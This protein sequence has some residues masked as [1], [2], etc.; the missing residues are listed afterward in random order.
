MDLLG[1]K[2]SFGYTGCSIVTKLRRGLR[3]W[4]RWNSPTYSKV[5]ILWH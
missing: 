2:G 3:A 5:N 4:E 1:K